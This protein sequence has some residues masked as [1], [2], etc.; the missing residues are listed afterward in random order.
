MTMETAEDR[1]VRMMLA[2]HRQACLESLLWRRYILTG[3]VSDYVPVNDVLR[4]FD[5]DAKAAPERAV[6]WDAVADGVKAIAKTQRVAG[7]PVS[8]LTGLK[9]K[10]PTSDFAIV[11]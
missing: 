4:E 10:A 11:R 7:R 2:L 8:V 5:V 6:R 9:P 1:A 3:N